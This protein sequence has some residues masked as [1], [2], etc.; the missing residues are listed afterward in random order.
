MT[1]CDTFGSKKKKRES[2]Y[3]T[4]LALALL[5]YVLWITVVCS[6]QTDKI[7]NRFRLKMRFYHLVGMV[8]FRFLPAEAICTRPASTKSP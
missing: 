1:L 2:Q 6:Y 5:R 4:V 7:L 8:V 3:A